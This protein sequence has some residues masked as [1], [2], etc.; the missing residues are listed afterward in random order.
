MLLSVAGGIPKTGEKIFFEG[1][2]CGVV[3]SATPAGASGG[4]VAL[5]Y[6]KKERAIAGTALTVSSFEEILSAAVVPAP[7]PFV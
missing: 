7:V 6:V 5:G 2:E 4:A 1:E 3:T